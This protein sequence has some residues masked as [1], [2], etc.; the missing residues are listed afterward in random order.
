MNIVKVSFCLVFLC[1]LLSYAQNYSA[2]EQAIIDV[3]TEQTRSYFERDYEAW[4]ATHV[5]A[6]YY[7]EHKYYEE[8]KD[9]VRATKGWAK[10]LENKKKQFDPNKPRNKWNAAKYQRSDMVIRISE[11]KDMAWVTYNQKAID[12]ETKEKIG[13]SYETRILE[14]KDGK[15]KIAYLGYHYLPKKKE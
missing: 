2:E 11:M 5:D 4:L 8:W 15:W 13:E 10:N 9:K 6:D 3:I 7:R 1:P 14:K 12:P